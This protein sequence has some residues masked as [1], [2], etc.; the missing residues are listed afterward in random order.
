MHTRRKPRALTLTL[1]NAK[2]PYFLL[3]GKRYTLRNVSQE[4]VGLWV[5][6]PAPFGLVPGAQVNGDVVIGNEIFPVGLEIRHVSAFL[7]GLRFVNCPPALSAIFKELLQPSHY[8]ATMVIHP[9]SGNEDPMNALNRLWYTGE[10][11]TELVV[12]YHELTRMVAALQIRWLG[13]WV[14]RK[15][16]EPTEMGWL[17]DEVKP[18][19]GSKVAERDLWTRDSVSDPQVIQQAAQFLTSVPPPFPGAVLWQFLE[20]GEQ[21]YLPETV[22]L[23]SQVA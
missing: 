5:K 6:A 13:R 12:W 23:K 19:P 1:P 18:L 8:A 17:K 3:E 7:V 2:Q 20:L 16:Y 10:S 22:V 11:G 4:G 14:Y 15:M 9:E 21:V